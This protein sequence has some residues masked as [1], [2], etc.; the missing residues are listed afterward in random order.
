MMDLAV[1][2]KQPRTNSLLNHRIMEARVEI[3]IKILSW[4]NRINHTLIILMDYYK[5]VK[6]SFHNIIPRLVLI[7]NITPSKIRVQIT[8]LS[9]N[10]TTMVGP[11]I[12]RT[13]SRGFRTTL[14][15]MTLILA[16]CFKSK[17]IHQDL[18][19]LGRLMEHHLERKIITVTITKL[20]ASL[21]T[22]VPISSTGLNLL[23]PTRASGSMLRIDA[24]DQRL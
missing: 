1:E 6:D 17:W 10:L 15:F 2:W 13:W 24:P 3:E 12:L 5:T 20:G 23:N 14:T 11:T 4:I 7:L 16:I 22:W 19:V 8:A 21:T 9:R 18:E